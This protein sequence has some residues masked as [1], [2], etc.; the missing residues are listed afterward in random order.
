MDN[1]GLTPFFHGGCSPGAPV[2]NTNA[3]KHGLYTAEARE[4]NR[5]LQELLKSCKETIEV[6]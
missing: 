3:L 4:L 2:G 1:R 6:L 5:Q